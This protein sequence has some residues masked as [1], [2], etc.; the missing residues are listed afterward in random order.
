MTTLSNRRQKGMAALEF[1]FVIPVLMLLVFGIVEFGI[2]FYREGVLAGAVREG[3]RAGI[4]ATNPRP[5]TGQIQDKVKNYLVGVGW[6][7]A[8][9][10]VTV[11]GA[12]GSSG[13]PLTVQASYPTNLAV[14]KKLVPMPGISVDS[15]GN[16]TLHA[17]IVMQL[18]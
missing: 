9:A 15:A 2:A 17:K 4:I 12:Q 8:P 1:G 10:Q 16:A 14:M 7:P 18:E 6:D 5:T 13:D 11:T 3:A